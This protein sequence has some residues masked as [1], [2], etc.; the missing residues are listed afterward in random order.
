MHS[1]KAEKLF[2]KQY[3]YSMEF[4]NHFEITDLLELKG[5]L[6]KKDGKY[7]FTFNEEAQ[8]WELSSA[9]LYN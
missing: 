9:K 4:G 2:K 5:V 6:Y 7:F 1:L 3:G 8:K